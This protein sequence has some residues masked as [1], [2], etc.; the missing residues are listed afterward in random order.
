MKPRPFVV[1]EVEWSPDGTGVFFVLHS[2]DNKDRWIATVDLDG[3]AQH[4]ESSEDADKPML[5]SIHHLRDEAWINWYFNEMAWLADSSGVWFLSEETGYS[6][7]Y[8]WDKASGETR[9]LTAG[10]FTVQDVVEYERRNM[11]LYRCNFFHPGQYEIGWASLERSESPYKGGPTDFS[12]LTEFGGTVEAFEISPDGSRVAMLYSTAMDPPEIY[13]QGVSPITPAFR[14]T[15]TDTDLY[16]SFD[17]VE[18]RFIEVQPDV[19]DIP[20]H[21]RVY[22]DPAVPAVRRRQA[23]RPVQPRRGVHPARLQRVVV[24]LPRTHVPHAAVPQRVHRDRAGFPRVPRVRARL[25]H[26]DLSQHGAS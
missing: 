12:V 3:L 14:L 19:N 17:W 7:L 24:L 15:D 13:V 16:R 22:D 10:Y 2:N 18:P 4:E 8:L 9:A 23:C 6:H 25:A 11:L 5:A 21:C 26:S 20:I 1:E